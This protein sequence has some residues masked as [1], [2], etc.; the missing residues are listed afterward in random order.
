MGIIFTAKEQKHI[1]DNHQVS[2]LIWF[3]KEEVKLKQEA[4]NRD[5]VPT[6][7]LTASENQVQEHAPHR[8]LCRGLGCFQGLLKSW[9]VSNPHC[10]LIPEVSHVKTNSSSLKNKSNTAIINKQPSE[11]PVWVKLPSEIKSQHR[12]QSQAMSRLWN[13]RGYS[14]QYVQQTNKKTKRWNAGPCLPWVISFRKMEH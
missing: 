5:Q 9:K 6:Q 2:I 1:I 13:K 3:I 12:W 4:V 14:H 10:P 7:Q 11:K 8:E